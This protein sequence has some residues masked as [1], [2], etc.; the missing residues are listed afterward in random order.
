MWAESRAAY[1]ARL[2][3]QGWYD[4]LPAH[5]R[6]EAEAIVADNSITVTI[7]L[8]RRW[9]YSL[10]FTAAGCLVHLGVISPDDAAKW[11]ARNAMRAIVE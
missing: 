2:L 1:E 8:E 11:I 6:A 9:W 5:K 10:A 3:R 7:G 4:R